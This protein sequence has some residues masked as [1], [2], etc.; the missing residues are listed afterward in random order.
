MLK[1]IIDDGADLRYV[2]YESCA[3]MRYTGQEYSLLVPLKNSSAGNHL[4]ES[5]HEDYFKRYGHSQ[6]DA[7]VEFVSLRIAGIVNFK[8][9]KS[10]FSSNKSAVTSPVAETNVI[11]N[12]KS[13]N[14]PIYSRDNIEKRIDGHAIILEKSTTIIVPKEWSIFPNEGDHLIMERIHNE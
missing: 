14:V 13:F 10:T 2:R 9:I 11:F 3:E 8:K 5:F 12:G 6:P 4:L 7:P 1:R